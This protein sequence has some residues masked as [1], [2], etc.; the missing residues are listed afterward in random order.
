MQFKKKFITISS[1]ALAAALVCGVNA[2]A[3]DWS[4]V[5]YADSDPSTVHIIST[6]ENSVHFCNSSTNTDICKARITLDK[7]LKNREDY[8][9]VRTVKWKVTYTGVS[10]DFTG[11]ALSGGTYLT[12]GGSTGYSIR[13][14][15]YDEENDKPIWKETEYTT[16]DFYTVPEDTPLEKDGELV[17]MDWSFADISNQGISLIISDLQFFDEDNNEIE[18]L[19]YGEW[20]AEMSADV[21]DSGA[22]NPSHTGDEEKPEETPAEE[23]KES[24]EP[25]EETAEPSEE[26]VEAEEETQESEKADETIE[27]VPKTGDIGVQIAFAALTAAVGAMFA[28]PKIK[29]E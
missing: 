9:K 17:F 19:G 15:E 7:V 6:D 21:I 14:E 22:G 4:Q 16:T 23:V 24:E 3:A 25:Q 2:S 10:P 29:K 28:I 20:T 11:D 27:E 18:Q 13:C 1:V 8:S 5:S 12:N 26:P